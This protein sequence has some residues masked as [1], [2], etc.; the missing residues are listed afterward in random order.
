MFEVETP[1]AELDRAHADVGRAHREL[2]HRIVDVD[3][4]E[5]WRAHGARDTAHL[6]AMRYGVSEWKAR[7]WIAAAHALEALPR[8]A[9]A[10]AT[11]ELGIDKVVELARFA[12]P[13]T[14][15]DLIRWAG[16]VSCA[17][18]RHRGD[19]AARTLLE[20]RSRFNGTARSAGGT[21]T[22]GV[23][24]AWR[25]SSRRADG[26]VVAR[27]LERL[28]QTI[29]AMPGESDG[30][31]AAA[32]RADALVALASTTVASDPDPD[33]ATVVIHA[34]AEGLVAG[35]GGCEIQDGPV[36][37]PETVK[38]LLCT[39]RVQE[40]LEDGDGT[41]RGVGRM[42]RQPAAWM[43]RQVRHRDRGC[44][45]PGRGARRFTE[46]HH[47]A[48][49]RYGGRTDLDNLALICSFHHRLVHE[50]GWRIERDVGGQMSWFLPDGIRYRAGPSSDAAAEP[51]LALAASG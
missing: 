21:S 25:P 18:V 37:H 40:V 2:L 12:T 30:S 9:E 20:A 15:A 22:T 24:S 5:A 42:S 45:F 46:A 23:A 8:L 14:E 34:Q 26:A 38:R 50:H 32:R 6:L 51:P 17:A 3:R 49:W 16:R 33:R 28:A 27:A 36:V 19:L 1:L 47:I 10:L 13:Q 31:F 11:G 48:W 39:G 43:L 29:P 44:T 4:S 35:T 7:R 41:V